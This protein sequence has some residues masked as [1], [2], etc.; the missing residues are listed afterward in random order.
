M[1]FPRRSAT[2][3]LPRGTVDV[4]MSRLNACR[5]PAGDAIAIGFVPMSPWRERVGATEPVVLV[6]EMPI[7]PASAA[8]SAYHPA[9]P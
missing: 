8:R 7:I 5:W 4:A 9:I 2:S 1:G 3:S 6:I